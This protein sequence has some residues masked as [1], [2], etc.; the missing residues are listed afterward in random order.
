MLVLGVGGFSS[1]VGKTALICNLVSVLPGWG[2]LKTSPGEPPLRLI[3]DPDELLRHGS[4][5]ARYQESGARRVAR[6]RCS[7]PEMEAGVALAM[8]SFSGLP[9]VLV[10]GNSFARYLEPSRM[11]LVARVGLD[12]VKSSA[13]DRIPTAHWIVL[14]R[15]RG[16]DPGLASKRVKQL[17]GEFN[18]GRI[19]V[20]DASSS[21]EPGTAAFLQEVR[22]WARR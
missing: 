11:I 4:D 18:L 16:S 21:E 1:G 12:E 6:L 20:L 8:E 7:L 15:E 5:T 14:N 3:T 22:T 17:A 2:V 10:E 19:V 13:R 9:G